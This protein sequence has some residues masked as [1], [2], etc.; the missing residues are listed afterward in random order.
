MDFLIITALP[1]E[2]DAVLSKLPSHRKTAA[3]EGHVNVCFESELP[4]LLPDSLKKSYSIVVTCL[5]RMGR[6]QAA[7]QTSYL[8]QH[9]R[10][11]YVMLVGIAGGA[12]ANGVTLGDVLISDEIIDYEI[13]KLTK[14]GP[15]ARFS[16]YRSD[17]RLLSAAQNLRDDGWKQLISPTRPRKGEPRC[18]PGPVAT[19]DKVVAL[20]KFLNELLQKWPKLIGV[21]MEAGGVASACYQAAHPPG[22]F[23]IRGVSDL[24]DAGKDKRATHKWRAYACDA[25]ASYAVGFLGSVPVLCEAP[26][27]DETFKPVEGSNNGRPQEPVEKA[28]LPGDGRQGSGS[29]GQESSQLSKKGAVVDWGEAPIAQPFWGRQS[30]L[31]KLGRWMSRDQ[32]RCRLLAL[33]GMTGVGK[34]SLTAHLVGKK[35]NQYDFVIWRSLHNAIPLRTL[36]QDLID[37]ISN[38]SVS[39]F[40]SDAGRL[41]SV[42][43]DFLKRSR[44]LVVLDNLEALLRKG[45]GAGRFQEQHKDYGELLRRIGTAEHHSCVVITSREKPVEIAALEGANRPIRTYTLEGL[46]PLVIRRL[47]KDKELHGTQRAWRDLTGCYSGNP[48][49]LMLVSEHIREIFGGNIDRFLREGRVICGNDLRELLNEEFDRL[50]DQEAQVLYWL[51]IEREP[52]DALVLQSDLIQW[53]P[54]SDIWDA[55]NSLRRRN[56]IER[57]GDS[58][59]LQNFVMEHVTEKFVNLAVQDILSGRTAVLNAHALRKALS[60]DY[61]RDSQERM[62]LR[63]V[64]QGLLKAVSQD[65]IVSQLQRLLMAERQRPPRTPGYAAANILSVL[66]ELKWNIRG[67]DFSSLTVKQAYLQEAEL[68][69]VSFANT[70]LTDTIF[71]DTFGSVTAVG[72]DKTGD[73]LAAGTFNG[74]VRIFRVADGKQLF[75]FV[76]HEDWV[77][78]VSFDSE[79]KMLASGSSD[80]TIRLWRLDDGRC[81]AVLKGH[82]DRIRSLSFVPNANRLVSGS[83]DK[84]IRLWDTATGESYALEGHSARIKT[85]SVSPDGKYLASGGDDRTIR[86]WDL[87]SLKCLRVIEEHTAW[88]RTLAFSPN[89]RWLV[90]GADDGSICVFDP[91]DGRCIRKVQGEDTKVW[92]VAVNNSGRVVASGGNDRT[93][94]LWDVS[95]FRCIKVLQAH[96]SWIRAI[97]FSPRAPLLAS[98]SED[99]TIKIWDAN[100]WRCLKTIRGY[101]SRVFS[102]AFRDEHSLVGG[103]GNHKVQIWNLDDG[104][105]ACSLRGH[106]D[107]VWSVAVSHDRRLVASGSDDRTV[108]LWDAKTGRALLT[109]EGHTSWIGSVAFSPDSKLIASGSDDRS[110]RLWETEGGRCVAILEGHEGRVSSVAFST[111]SSLIASGSEDGTVSIWDVTGRKRVRSLLGHNSLVFSVA[112]SPKDMLLASGSGDQTIRLWSVQTGECASVLRGHTRQV[113]AVAFTPDADLLAS[114]SDDRTIR[115]WDVGTSECIKVLEG[116]IRQVW[117]VCFSPDGTKLASASEDETVRIWRRS[118][119]WRCAQILRSERPYERMNI[120]GAHGLTEAQRTTLRGLGALEE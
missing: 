76:G 3:S 46:N 102:I 41:I 8:V 119:N 30:E 80:Q 27:P 115:V 39:D 42:F 33:L 59:S 88:V 116:H 89:S 90:S 68:P 1:E 47:L 84:T 104:S 54:G 94:R 114:A 53:E 98:G 9:Y 72:F 26:P 111:D 6:V 85:I 61:V 82:T 55:L 91:A 67:W 75:N 97:C 65:Y 48:A 58:F 87:S 37:F 81:T 79:N 38:H 22:F 52:T 35:E 2:Q 10:P 106:T 18:I 109:L 108:R 45:K 92:A 4:I 71:A 36:L 101:T 29:A 103:L 24:A 56:L 5:A 77:S 78:G 16:V 86:L 74:Q 17:P 120:S 20:K 66:T 44:C 28:H 96:S 21:E 70:D 49:A 105:F 64:I 13:Q 95:S 25:A 93:L 110:I 73:R 11:R 43:L 100:A 32:P 31:R 63:P 112:F 19:G 60:R 12:S 7:V 99:Q 14:K 23:M 40:P 69:E 118:E 62:I 113:W 15:K 107:Q 50:S 51:A 34:T 117:C 57:V 83:E